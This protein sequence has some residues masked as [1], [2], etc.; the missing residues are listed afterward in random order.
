MYHDPRKKKTERFKLSLSE[1]EIQLIDIAL[2]IDG[3]QRAVIA[4][5]VL[6]EWAKA[7]IATARHM[8][9]RASFGVVNPDGEIKYRFAA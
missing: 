3:G 4:R 2:D 7:T 9:G 6:L 1:E 5:D 8:P